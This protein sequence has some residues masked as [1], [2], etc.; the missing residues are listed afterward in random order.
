MDIIKTLTKQEEMVKPEVLWFVLI[1]IYV[2]V[3]TENRQCQGWY[4]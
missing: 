4:R 1:L 3:L 2:F